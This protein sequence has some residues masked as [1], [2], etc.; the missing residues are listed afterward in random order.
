MMK[1]RENEINYK[2]LKDLAWDYMF[3]SACLSKDDYDTLKGK[4]EAEGGHKV[5]P[6]WLFV[7]RNTK[8]ILDI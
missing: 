8:V 2:E 5:T 7:A 4:W 3:V 1:P 6:W